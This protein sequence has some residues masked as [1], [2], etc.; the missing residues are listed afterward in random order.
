MQDS[1]PPAPGPLDGVRIVDISTVMAA[2]FATHVLADHGADVIKVESPTGDIMRNSAQSPEPQ[3]SP[4]FQHMNRNKRSIVLD[5]K[6]ADDRAVLLDLVASA[7]A[8]V[9]NMRPAVMARLELDY[10]SVRAA[11][12]EIVYCGV[13]GYGRGG[14]YE[15]RPAY[16][17]LVQGAVAI[18][19]LNTTP[20][21]GPRFVPAAIIDRTTG[22]YMAN[23]LLMA[24]LR[25]ERT[26][27]GAAVEVPM[28]EAAAH[29][30]LVE[31]MF[32]RSFEP[33]VGTAVNKRMLQPDRRPFP[34]SDGFVC[35]L[36]YTNRNW[37]DLSTILGIDDVTADP[38]F[39]DF[40][41]RR[42]NIGELYALLAARLSERT[43]DEWLASCDEVDIPASRCATVDELIDDPHL[44]ERG[45]FRMVP[46]GHGMFRHMRSPIEWA[47]WSPPDPRP[48]P[49][50]GEH[51]AEIT[52]TRTA[53][54]A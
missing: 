44:A 47:D 29:F 15:N 45:F 11:N 13:I 3:M 34:T 5:L 42:E 32:G 48:A 8:F 20:A 52:R 46:D 22:L 36:P 18:P 6:S 51:S 1:D 38:R 50:L 35:V 4:I 23:A 26:G 41:A 10:A 14:R 9:Y 28:F 43:T 7:D 24:L 37:R 54:E 21:A 19:T 25:R 16:D 12:P 49:R 17:D 40:P 27:Q 53:R 39:A 2:P 31:H 33:P 30:L